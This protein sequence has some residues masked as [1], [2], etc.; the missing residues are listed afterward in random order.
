M[1]IQKTNYGKWSQAYKCMF[2]SLELIVVTEIGPRIMSFGF[3]DGENILYEDK[4][5]FSFG[6]WRI[7]GGHRL[8]VAPESS[9]SYEPDNGHCEVFVQ[10]N[11]LKITAPASSN[12]IQKILE[13]SPDKNGDGFKVKHIIKNTGNL[14]ITAAPWTVTCVK[15]TEHLIIPWASGSKQWRNRKVCYINC[16]DSFN[17]PVNSPQWQPTD[18][19]FIINPNGQTGKIGIY[20]D[21]GLMARLG[22]NSTF[23][24]YSKA[25]APDSSYPDSGCN[26]EIYTNPKYIEM[27]FLGPIETVYPG[28]ELTLTESW[29]LKH[30]S[31]KP[32]Q[33][34]DVFGF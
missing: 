30:E 17:A 31:F 15:T 29:Q 20:S 1:N 24:K 6:N 25:I 34:Q 21:K 13:I 27:E 11:K 16:N 23:I 4:S 12:N 3:K 18:D 28:N 10:K 8:T 26:I 7:Y 19:L 33:W 9:L 5:D 14:L 32:E 2:G 22:A